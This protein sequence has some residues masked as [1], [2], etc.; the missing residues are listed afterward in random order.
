S[1]DLE[2]VDVPHHS[3]V[4]TNFDIFQKVIIDWKLLHNRTDGLP[5]IGACLLDGLQ[6]MK[7]RVVDPCLEHVGRR[8][9]DGTKSL[10]PRSR[11]IV[12]IPVIVL[13]QDRSLRRLQAKCMH[14]VD[15]EEGSDELG[16][17]L[18]QSELSCLL[19]GVDEI[20]ASIS[21][22]NDFGATGLRLQQKGGKIGCIERMVDATKNLAA[23]SRD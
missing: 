14:V 13:G 2:G 12:Q 4:A 22:C 16:A 18:R 19:N 23:R 10:V 21:Q 15:Q 20:R 6:I 17:V 11:R 7:N 5:V 1:L 8:S 9:M 3:T